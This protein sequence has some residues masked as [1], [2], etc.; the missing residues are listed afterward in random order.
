MPP[1]SAQQDN[2]CDFN[3]RRRSRRG[4]RNCRLRKIKCDETKPGCEKCASY[5]VRCNYQLGIP[6]LEAAPGH[7]PALH[8]TN[9]RQLAAPRAVSLTKRPLKTTITTAIVQGHSVVP[10]ELDRDSI[11]LLHR[12]RHRTI[13]ALGTPTLANIFE[14][15]F[16]SMAHQYPCL[17]HAYLALAAVYERTIGMPTVGVRRKELPEMY[18]LS[19][20]AQFFNQKLNLPIQPRDRDPIWGTA[21]FLGVLSFALH[22]AS[23]PEDAWPIKQSES[24]DLHWIRI[25]KGKMAVWNLTQPTRPDSIFRPM[26]A[27]YSDLA[28]PLPGW[29]IDGVPPALASLCDLSP[30]STAE[31]SPYFNAVHAVCWLQR[32]PDDQ[33]SSSRSL[34]FMSRMQPE[35]VSLLRCKDPV[36]LL[37]LNRWYTRVGPFLWWIGLRAR[38]ECPS[39]SLYLQRH[40]KDNIAVRQLVSGGLTQCFSRA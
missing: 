26:A 16:L 6:D 22:N 9:H 8:S 32:L 28:S 36:A 25:G 24:S 21:A 13:L 14:K 20:C 7:R 12:F 23:R 4:C 2:V 29:G 35:F 1:G 27:I 31:T 40:H 18:H 34:V 30:A 15:D 33:I 11:E 3:A 37:L 10:F 19:Q 5:G 39:I 17:M 38:V